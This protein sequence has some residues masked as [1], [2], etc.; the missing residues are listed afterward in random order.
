MID[1]LRARIPKSLEQI[2]EALQSDPEKLFS[3]GRCLCEIKAVLV[4]VQKKIIRMLQS[5]LEREADFH[6]HF[7][8]GDILLSDPCRLGLGRGFYWLF[9]RLHR[10]I[11]ASENKKKVCSVCLRSFS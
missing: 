1:L 8:I 5:N 4:Q 10:L 7:S 11:A 6:H 3:S 9:H 2:E